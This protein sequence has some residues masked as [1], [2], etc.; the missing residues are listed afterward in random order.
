MEKFYRFGDI[1]F[2]VI[3]PVPMREDPRFE[4]FAE[5]FTEAD[6]SYS[7]LPIT[8]EQAAATDWPVV[9]ERKGKQITVYMN[10][11][12]LPE[13][14][15][16]NLLIS[17][18]AAEL[19]PE[20]GA[21]VLHASYVCHNGQAILFTAPCETGKS[22]QARFW[23]AERNATVVNEDRVLI[24]KRQDGYYAGGI[25]A[26]G[27]AG[28]T[29]NVTAPIRAIVLLGQGKEN[30]VQTPRPAIALS[31]LM[32]Q[33]TYLDTDGKSID[34]MFSILLDLI[35]SVR[36]LSYDCIN[37]PSSVADLEKYL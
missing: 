11:A 13:I 4:A 21:F 20:A 37:H 36:I 5:D 25:W 10:T 1:R 3:T 32:P 28:I 16:A 2:S 24:F 31:K 15:V 30:R 35:P 22:T 8:P 17:A 7:V 9:T 34:R 23:E 6:F 33:C 27:S 19:L 12:L 29:K 18:R 14:T 26:T